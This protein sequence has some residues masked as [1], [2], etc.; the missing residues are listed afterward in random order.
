MLIVL[1]RLLLVSSLGMKP[2]K[3]HLVIVFFNWAGKIIN[4]GFSGKLF[5]REKPL[6]GDNKFFIVGIILPP[7]GKTVSSVLVR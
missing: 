3:G 5:Q 1:R 7:V 6:I 4:A 2:C